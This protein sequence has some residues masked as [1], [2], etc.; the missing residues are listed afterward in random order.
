MHFVHLRYQKWILDQVYEYIVQESFSTSFLYCYALGILKSH[1]RS[2][3]QENINYGFCF[4]G[5]VNDCE[6]K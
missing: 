5:K 6:R 1:F 3:D 4:S 2:F